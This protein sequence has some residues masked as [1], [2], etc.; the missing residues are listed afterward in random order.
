MKSIKLPNNDDK[1]EIM[2]VAPKKVSKPLDDKVSKFDNSIKHLVNHLE[3]W[4]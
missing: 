4:V 1:P 2:I 3:I